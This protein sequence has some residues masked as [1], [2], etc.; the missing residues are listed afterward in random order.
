MHEC[1]GADCGHP[2]HKEPE[3]D[4]EGEEKEEE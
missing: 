2:E 4:A 1:E 3:T